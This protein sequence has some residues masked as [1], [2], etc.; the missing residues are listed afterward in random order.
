MLHGDMEDTPESSPPL[1]RPI[2]PKFR[3]VKLIVAQILAL[4][5]RDRNSGWIWASKFLLDEHPGQ[6]P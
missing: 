6:R 2:H 5:R 1:N 3:N 4:G